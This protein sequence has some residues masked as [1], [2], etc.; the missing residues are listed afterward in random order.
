MDYLADGS[1]RE[2]GRI[3]LRILSE[4]A[5]IEVRKIQ[6]PKGNKYTCWYVSA[7]G[8]EKLPII[9]LGIYPNGRLT[10][11]FRFM[12]FLSPELR[13]L[14]QWQTTNW[15]YLKVGQK[16]FSLAQTIQILH[17]YVPQVCSAASGGLL[18]KG[19][20]SAAETG[21]SDILKSLENVEFVEG[22]RPEWLRNPEGNLLQL[23]FW[24]TSKGL[25]IEVQ[26]PYHFSD[27]HGKPHQLRRRQEND[28]QK[29][30][31]C[32]EQGVSL[33][34]MNSVGIQK[35][36]VRM[37]FQEQVEHLGRLLKFTAL[38][39]PCHVLWETPEADPKIV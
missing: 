28:K 25:A 30:R 4:F 20:T 9:N 31:I 2:A 35:Y 8:Y 3:A 37:P 34:W 6:I 17:G 19:G 16:P 1:H 13:E 14:M 10:V 18:K 32:L 39:H 7:V 21:V 26:G 12:E 11:E 24:L 38:H 33:I 15:P 27:L 5:R 23:D 22:E 29:I 36:L